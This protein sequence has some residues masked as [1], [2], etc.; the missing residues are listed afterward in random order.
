[1]VIQYFIR[2]VLLCGFLLGVVPAGQ[3]RELYRY[4][5]DEGTMVVDFKVPA[6]YISRGY[7][8]VNS[9][10]VVI[11]VVPRELTEAEQLEQDAQEKLEARAQAEQERLRKWDESLLLRY[12]TVEDIEAARERALRDLR[13]RVSILK[14]NKRSLKQQVESYQEQAANMERQGQKVDVARLT[15]I[16][17]LQHEI[18]ATDR[19]II[20]R[21]KEIADVSSAYQKDIER[22]ERLLEIVELRRSLLAQERAARESENTDPRR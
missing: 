18:E 3:S 14:S 9:K 15:A 22:F 7:E 12:S 17:N 10:G 21:Q 19:A 16:E 13:I 6:E 1:M 11:K 2:Y 4:Y 5:N 20:D 8:V